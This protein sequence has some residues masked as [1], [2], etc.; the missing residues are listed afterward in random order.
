MAAA[1]CKLTPSLSSMAWFCMLGL[2]IFSPL[3]N[4]LVKWQQYFFCLKG[5]RTDT[6]KL[7][8]LEKAPSLQI[9]TLDNLEI[10]EWQKKS[11]QP[12][13]YA[14]YYTFI[15]SLCIIFSQDLY[16][17]D[18]GG[19]I[20]SKHELGLCSEGECY[21]LSSPLTLQKQKYL[22]WRKEKISE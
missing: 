20:Y 16:K 5:S 22:Y 18:C 8:L 12:N 14:L 17:T 6:C 9:Q 19:R 7:K 1:K 13:G 15:S 21:L 4:Q 11:L 2:S 10:S 3:R